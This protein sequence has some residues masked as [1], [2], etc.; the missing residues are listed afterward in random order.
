[1]KFS[2]T[3]FSLTKRATANPPSMVTPFTAFGN[4]SHLKQ[5]HPHVMEANNLLKPI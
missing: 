5:K 3:F 2:L 1:V 4:I